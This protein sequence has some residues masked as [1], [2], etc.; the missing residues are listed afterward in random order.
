MVRPA[1]LEPA[2]PALE[3]RST[4]ISE[5]LKLPRHIKPSYSSNWRWLIDACG[6]LLAFEDVTIYKINYSGLI[7]L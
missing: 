3:G 1:G 2:P 5:K 4:Q 7:D 6:K